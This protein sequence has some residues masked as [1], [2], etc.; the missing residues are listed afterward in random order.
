VGFR[1]DGSAAITAVPGGSALI[2]V[3]VQT[4]ST[5]TISVSGQFGETVRL[6]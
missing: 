4:G 5:A 3:D 2:V 1:V 6:R